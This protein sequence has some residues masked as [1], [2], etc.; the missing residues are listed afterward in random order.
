M[1]QQVDVDKLIDYGGKTLAG[2]AGFFATD[3]LLFE[4]LCWASRVCWCLRDSL[5]RGD[6]VIDR[7]RHRRVAVPCFR[8]CSIFCGIGS[9]RLN[10][11][12][13]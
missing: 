5:A 1:A 8:A 12:G 13:R 4:A 6:P 7:T 2:A 11:L 9:C 3:Q 10:E